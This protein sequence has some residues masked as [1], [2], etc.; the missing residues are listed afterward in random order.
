VAPYLIE[1]DTLTETDTE[2]DTETN[3]EMDTNMDK[4]MDKDTDKDTDTD[5]ELEYFCYISI[6]RY[7]AV[8]IT[9]DKSRR[10]FQQR[11]KL[12]APLANENCDMINLKN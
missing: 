8:W 11:Y 4:D 9:N 12:V 7:S 2:T 10:K 5:M 3:T 6:R 1:M